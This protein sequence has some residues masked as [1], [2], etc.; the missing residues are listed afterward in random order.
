MMAEEWKRDQL[1]TTT[2][3][4]T[5][6]RHAGCWWRWRWSVAR[7]MMII[8]ILLSAPTPA[9]GKTIN[10]NNNNSSLDRHQHNRNYNNNNNNDI[11]RLV[12][13]MAFHELGERC[14]FYGYFPLNWFR[15]AEFCH[16]FGRGVS[17]ATIETATENFYIKK[18]LAV[19]G[20][21]NTG[22]WVGGS[23]NGHSGKWAWFPTGQLVDYSNWGPSQPSGGDQ[24]CMY[25]VGGLL[26]YQWADFHCDFDMHF[27]CEYGVNDVQPWR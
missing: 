3:T 16:S 5:T 15:A 27:L 20:D 18:W 11:T 19:N 7:V 22:V 4:T 8:I 2:T 13:P 12:C 26:G 6:R 24:H 9:A 23:D 1:T 25:L 14:Y 17:L 21:H 10:D